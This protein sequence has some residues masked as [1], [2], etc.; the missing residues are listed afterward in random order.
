M[1]KQI[2]P[3][4]YAIAAFLLLSNNSCLKPPVIIPHTP[5][6]EITRLKGLT[7]QLFEDSINITY[8]NKNNPVSLIG[9]RVQTGYPQFLIGYDPQDRLR[10]I[11]GAYYDGNPNY[12]VAHKYLLDTRKRVM[13]DSI[14][15]FGTYDRSTLT[16]TTSLYSFF[17]KKYLY[18]NQDRITQVINYRYQGTAYADVVTTT[19]FY[20][21]AGNAYKINTTVVGPGNTTSSND[22]FPVYD[23]KIN[24]HQL[25]PIWQL[26]DVDYS[27]N[28]AFVADSYNNYG[29][30]LQINMAG[31]PKKGELNFLLFSFV[32]LEITYRK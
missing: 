25:H 21:S 19:Y 18:D 11:I 2:Y 5:F 16:I 15:N 12:E 13:I 20:N 29:L 6:F 28:N 22:A 8:N 24:P 14:F 3:V 32:S 7:T 9:S 17:V 23:N 27:K 30:P 31:D 4:L 10:V 26:I 1:K